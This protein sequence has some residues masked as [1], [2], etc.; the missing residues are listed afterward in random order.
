ME[1]I[2]NPYIGLLLFDY[3]NEEVRIEGIGCDWIVARNELAE[4]V[5]YGFDS[6]NEML[7]WISECR[8]RQN[9]NRREPDEREKNRSK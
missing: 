3:H 9:R 5:F 8:E 7:A 6:N 1:Q 4:P 2:M